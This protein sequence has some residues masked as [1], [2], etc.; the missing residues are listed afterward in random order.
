MVQVSMGHKAFC[1]NAL[2]K[3]VPKKLLQ[4]SKKVPQKEEKR[5]L[6]SQANLKV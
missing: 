6:L 3:S 1:K 4:K 5:S 2:Q